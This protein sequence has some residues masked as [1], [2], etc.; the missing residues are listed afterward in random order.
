MKVY[1]EIA[2]RLNAAASCRKDS[3][4]R[5]WEQ[6]HLQR[7]EEVVREYLPR[8]S[9]FDNGTTIS[10]EASTSEKLVFD[11]SFHHMN[12]G[13]MYDG[14]T[15]HQVVVRPSLV[16]G[17]SI[18]VTGKNRNEVKDFIAAAFEQALNEESG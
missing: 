14:W 17:F 18:R 10:L 16:F 6:K 3:A 7:V 15:S 1:E 8:G 11:T 12:E 4:C 5:D 2:S 13:G 9:G